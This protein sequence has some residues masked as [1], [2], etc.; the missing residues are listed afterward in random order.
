MEDEKWDMPSHPHEGLLSHFYYMLSLVH[1]TPCLLDLEDAILLFFFLS[2]ELVGQL[3]GSK[4]VRQL[5]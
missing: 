2:S 1:R 3:Q 5:N 4:S